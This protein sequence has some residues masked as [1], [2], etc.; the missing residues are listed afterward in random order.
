MEIEIKH[1]KKEFSYY[2]KMMGL[3][4][5]L[6]NLFHRETL[7]KEAVRDISFSVEKGEIIGLLGPN[8][9]GKT[10][11]LKMLS[12]IL[13]PTSGQALVGGF[14]PW[15]RKMHLNN[16]SLSLWARKIN[17]GGTYLQVTA[18]ISTN[19]FSTL[20]INSISEQ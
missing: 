2:K 17:Y 5:S 18:F 14:I 19:A 20:A 13:H 9:A 7:I 1:L 11:T 10:T 4:G 8:G 15:E 12:G 16:A 6:H 3:S